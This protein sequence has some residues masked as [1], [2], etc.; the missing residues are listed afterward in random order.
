MRSLPLFAACL[1]LWSAAL[2]G[3]DDGT[4]TGNPDRNNG[5]ETAG[6]AMCEADGSEPLTLDQ[7]TSLG[8]RVSEVLAFVEGTHEETLTWYPQEIAEYGPES[9]QQALTLTVTRKGAPRFARYR[10]KQGSGAGLGEIA[11]AG[12]GCEP[13]V[14]VDVDITL[15][16]AQGALNETLSTT[17]QIRSPYVVRVWLN[18]DPN[19]LQGSFHITQVNQPGFRLVQLNLSA[20]FTP[21]GN[22]G[23]L[24]PTF[25]KRDANSV[26]ASAGGRQPLASW[27]EQVACDMGM[28]GVPRDLA[29]E[30]FSADDVVSLWNGVKAPTVAFDNL[31]ASALTLAPLQLSSTCALLERSEAWG[32]TQVGTIAVAGSVG[33]KS[34][35]GHI[36]GSWPVLLVATPKQGGGIGSVKVSFTNE[37][38]GA[39][40]SLR[41]FDTAGYDST[42]A[43]L[44]GTLES[45]GA[46]SAKV[47][48]N[49]LK[50]PNC[51]TEPVITPGGGA[52]S[53]G[54][55]GADVKIIANGQISAP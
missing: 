9:G 40:A 48:L 20:Q 52:S 36:D 8:F 39:A 38:T 44:M 2:P 35:D 45:S 32:L 12:G 5:G 53:P 3:C 41:G 30:G 55:P 14:E 37:A 26:G 11:I 43:T 13:A 34:A 49:G 27:G 17:L 19:K 16:T 54:C 46:L 7:E 42:H 22:S 33:V 24:R 51:P 21:Y 10:M 25:E 28:V 15:R 4:S 31:P 23:E 1:G 18:P 50:L 29:L 6:S 47:T